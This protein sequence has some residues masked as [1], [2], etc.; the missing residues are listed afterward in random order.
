M[1]GFMLN[2]QTNDIEAVGGKIKLLSTVQESVRQSLSIKLRTFQ[3]EWFLDTLFGV[4]YRGINGIIGGKKSK[5]EVD[6]IF[7]SI[8][9]D[10]PEVER[11]I[12]FNS[13]FNSNRRHYDLDFDVRVADG[14]LRNVEAN[15]RPDEEIEYPAGGTT[16]TPTCR[17]FDLNTELCRLHTIIHCKLPACGEYTWITDTS[18]GVC[19]VDYCVRYVEQDYVQMGYVKFDC[20]QISTSPQ[21]TPLPPLPPEEYVE[22]DYVDPDYV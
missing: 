2:P 3:G 8:I 13:V 19:D 12:S 14:M 15:L 17:P 5:A 9:N 1:I 7:I 16:I 20:S 4:P 18:G 11:I 10:E 22:F 6:A 21:P